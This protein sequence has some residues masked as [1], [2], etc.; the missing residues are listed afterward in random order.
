MHHTVDNA[1]GSILQEKAAALLEAYR[2]SEVSGRS[3]LAFQELSELSSDVCPEESTLC[4]ALL[5]LQREKKCIVS[6]H[7]GEKV[8]VI[9]RA[10]CVCV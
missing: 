9:G 2:G 8:R 5:Q 3:L 1:T 6:L 10:K 7:E 4:M